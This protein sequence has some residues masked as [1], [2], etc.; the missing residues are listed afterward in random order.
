MNPAIGYRLWRVDPADAWTGNQLESLVSQTLWPFRERLEAACETRLAPAKFRP[1]RAHPVDVHSAPEAEC[2][3]G[4]YAYHD[5]DAMLRHVEEMRQFIDHR[6][7][8][9]VAGAVLCWGRLVIHPEGF[10]AQFARVVAISL[11]EPEPS[12]AWTHQHLREVARA[13]A[14][15][16]LDLKHLVPYARE[17][18]SAFKP[19]PSELRQ[20][21][22]FGRMIPDWVGRLRQAFG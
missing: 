6:Q 4:V 9:L 15:P 17:F 16:P 2:T 12:T 14:I 22:R 11:P 8:I 10:R 20:R 21:S 19:D 5:V 13:Y 7:R 1:R 18:G 3:C